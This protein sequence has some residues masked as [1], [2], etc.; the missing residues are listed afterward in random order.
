M[1]RHIH[2]Y[3]CSAPHNPHPDATADYNEENV[4]RC[5]VIF[6]KCEMAR[7]GEDCGGST[8]E[9][10]VIKKEICQWCT[11]CVL[12]LEMWQVKVG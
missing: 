7:W 5:K 8:V 2:I 12:A 10:V 6:D 11:A 9:E 4:T 3:H 1:C